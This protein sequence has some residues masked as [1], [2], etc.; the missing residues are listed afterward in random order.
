MYKLELVGL[1]VESGRSPANFAAEVDQS[2]SMVRLESNRTLVRAADRLN[3]YPVVSSDVLA[4][5]RTRAPILP[6]EAIK[7]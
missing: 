1:E 7:P 5:R 3:R 2:N 4:P 6:Q